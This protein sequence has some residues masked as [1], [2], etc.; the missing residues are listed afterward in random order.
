MSAS[1]IALT[2]ANGSHVRY[3]DPLCE[4]PNIVQQRGREAWALCGGVGIKA[5]NGAE[6][7]MNLLQ[8]ADVLVLPR[9]Q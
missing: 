7:L 4:F 1:C 9:P 5:D 8:H 3:R 6:D 2:S